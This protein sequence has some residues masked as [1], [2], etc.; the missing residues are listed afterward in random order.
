MPIS[1]SRTAQ[2]IASW[3]R[4]GL[5]TSFRIHLVILTRPRLRLRYILPLRLLRL[6]LPRNVFPNPNVLHL[7]T[8][9]TGAALDA[10]WAIPV[11][12]YTLSAPRTERA[13]SRP[14]VPRRT[15]LPVLITIRTIVSSRVDAAGGKEIH[16]PSVSNLS[17]QSLNVCNNGK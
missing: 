10:V 6:R 14:F 7:P 8:A 11:K 15:I 9:S 17:P 12:S 3:D 4:T 13:D 1:L 5:H 2:I 16:R